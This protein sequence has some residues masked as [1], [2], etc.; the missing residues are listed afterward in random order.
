MANGMLYSTNVMLK[1]LLQERY[2]GDRHYVWCSEHFD[3]QT[4]PKY[5][6]SYHVAPSANPA[7]IFRQ[8][9]QD[10]DRG[11]LHSTKLGEQR[12]SFKARAHEWEKTGTISATDREDIIYMVDNA[13]SKDWRPLIYVI[14]REPVASRLQSVPASRR[15]G[16]GPEYI[17]A[18][19]ARHEFDILEL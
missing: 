18:D 8:I 10:V 4:L 17:I 1:L 11:D 19:L 2:A 13:T 9:K 16:I 3:S 12:A 6:S 5:S 7:D 15:A 14:H